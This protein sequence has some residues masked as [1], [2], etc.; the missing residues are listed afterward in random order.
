M[1]TALVGV[2][3]FAF[4]LGFFLGACVIWCYCGKKVKGLQATIN[5]TEKRLRNLTGI[6]VEQVK[7]LKER[8]DARS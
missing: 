7:D 2:A 4:V 5:E 3:G 6:I 8:S 1:I